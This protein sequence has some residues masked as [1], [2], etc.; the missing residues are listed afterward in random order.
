MADNISGSVASY[1]SLRRDPLAQLSSLM[2]LA[3]EEELTELTN[4]DRFSSITSEDDF[5]ILDE[6]EEDQQQLTLKRTSINT[7]VCTDSVQ[8]AT[9]SDIPPDRNVGNKN[10]TVQSSHEIPLSPIQ[11]KFLRDRESARHTLCSK[12]ERKGFGATFNFQQRQ[13]DIESKGE[14]RHEEALELIE[15]SVIEIRQNISSDLLE[16]MSLVVDIADGE[17]TVLPELPGAEDVL[18]VIDKTSGS[19][20]FVG[21]ADTIDCLKK[22]ITKSIELLDKRNKNQEE[23]GAS[24]SLHGDN[25]P[26]GTS[27]PEQTSLH[28]RLCNTPREEHQA[29]DPA[30]IKD[31][32]PVNDDCLDYLCQFKEDEIRSIGEKEGVSIS[33]TPQGYEVR[34][35]A[36]AV[37][38]AVVTLRNTVER[39]KSNKFTFETSVNIG[40]FAEATRNAS[41]NHNCIIGYKQTIGSVRG[42]RRAQTQPMA[43]STTG[44]QKV[45]VTVVL[46]RIENQNANVIV[47]TTNKELKLSQGHGVS[48]SLLRVAGDEIQQVLTDIY[49]HGMTYGDLAVSHSGRLT[50]CEKI[51]H[52]ALPH[53]TGIKDRL[54]LSKCYE[55]LVSLVFRCLIQASKDGFETIALPAFG[56]GALRYPTKNVAQLMYHA[57]DLFTQDERAGPL[58]E[59]FIVISRESRLEV[60]QLFLAHR[61]SHKLKTRQLAH[62]RTGWNPLLM[63][64]PFL[65]PV[66]VGKGFRFTCLFK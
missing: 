53:H 50:T 52:G 8:Q 48:H 39:V 41:T 49:P 22:T 61:L 10:D 11:Q 28:S 30:P 63:L 32:V 38:R 16:Q 4:D 44:K 46:D 35:A 64:I 60:K 15:G 29:V 47:N 7:S 26:G 14:N 5:I 51:Y 59:I 25:E 58:K 21:M 62:P 40:K 27:A 45:K 12:L 65:H 37:G 6:E 9:S 36:T 18:A 20:T 2:K 42:R 56:T 1:L 43:S 13:V 3:S 19:M 17:Q 31:F 24:A 54:A 23:Q 57:I 66:T 55:W 33:D 34:G